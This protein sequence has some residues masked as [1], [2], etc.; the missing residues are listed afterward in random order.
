[1]L[2]KVQRENDTSEQLLQLTAAMGSP[3]PPPQRGAPA[4]HV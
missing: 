1:M 2:V 3:L 4:V